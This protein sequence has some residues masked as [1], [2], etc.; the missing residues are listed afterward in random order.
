MLRGA[1]DQD[2]A[3][4]VAPPFTMKLIFPEEVR[5]LQFNGETGEP[6]NL[7]VENDYRTTG[8]VGVGASPAPAADSG[9]EEDAVDDDF[10]IDLRQK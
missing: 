9:A 10:P 7:D 3:T 1:I 6:I 8:A 5:E 4:E 2:I